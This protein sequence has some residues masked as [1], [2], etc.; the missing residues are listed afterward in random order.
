MR[1]MQ[2]LLWSTAVAL[3]MCLPAPAVDMPSY[4]PSKSGS[5]ALHIPSTTSGV[6]ISRVVSK[7][8]RTAEAMYDWW[9]KTEGHEEDSLCQRHEIAASMRRTTDA[10]ARAALSK[11]LKSLGT[12]T[13]SKQFSAMK[14]AFCGQANHH[15]DSVCLSPTSMFANRSKTRHDLSRTEVYQWYCAKSGA[16]EQS[17]CKAFA[18]RTKMTAPGTSLDQKKEILKQLREL[19]APSTAMVQAATGQFCQLPKNIGKPV[20]VNMK[21]FKQGQQLKKWYCAD[22]ESSPWCQREKLLDQLRQMPT[23]SLSP[24]ASTSSIATARKELVKKMAEMSRSGK[25]TEIVAEYKE[26]KKAFCA[27]AENKVLSICG[28]PLSVA[29]GGMHGHQ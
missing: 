25:G 12:S 6:P 17:M 4:K 20:C 10:S 16:A 11:K 7:V 28:L 26:A 22:K 18:L 13:L 2:F 1:S 3:V 8:S 24:D 27:L 5:H 15:H 23:P 19:G 14:S 9:C 29:Q 21:T